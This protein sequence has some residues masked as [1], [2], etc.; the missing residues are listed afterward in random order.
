MPLSD[1]QIKY[2]L[3]INNTIPM[4]KK[5]QHIR[6]IE[7]KKRAIPNDSMSFVRIS[8]ISV[9]DSMPTSTRKTIKAVSQ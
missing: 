1:I 6:Y 3:L 9:L 4:K 5:P 8:L 2:I 7:A